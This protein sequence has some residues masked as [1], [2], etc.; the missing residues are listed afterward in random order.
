MKRTLQTY[1]SSIAIVALFF[2]GG[3]NV[4]ISQGAGYFNHQFLQPILINAGATG[5]QGDHQLLAGY[6]HMWST[7]PD[8][9]RT[10]TALYHGSFADNL[11][12]GF[13]VMTDQ[14]GVAQTNTGQLNFAY[15]LNMNDVKLGIGLSAGLETFKISDIRDDQLIDPTDVLLNEALDGYMFFDGSVGIYG[16]VREKLFFGISFPDLIKERLTNISGNINV[17]DFNTFAYAFLLGYRFDI[18]N[19]DFIIEPSITVKDLRYSPFLIDLNLKF[20]FLEEQLVG[21]IGYTLGDNSRASLLLGTRINQLRLYYSYDVNL[22]KFQDYSNGS[23]E[24]TL[25]YRIPKKAE[26]AP[27]QE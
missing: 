18:E 6:K 26:V 3:T 12:I 22:G 20:S 15:R 1:I 19:Y 4:A 10:F 24:L 7:F 23:H 5:F 13:Q 9:P 8:A 2:V 14:V 16:E 21:G 25:V 27:I 17:P 11:G